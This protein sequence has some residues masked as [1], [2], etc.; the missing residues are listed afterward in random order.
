MQVNDFVIVKASEGE[1]WRSSAYPEQ[2]AAVRAAGKLAGAYHFAW[3]NQNPLTEAANFVGAADLRPGE[4]AALDMEREKAG[5]SWETRVAYALAWCDE[6]KRLTGA[7]PLVY[8]N[9]SWVKGLRSA[10]TAT[11]WARLTKYPCWLAEWSGTAGDFSTIDGQTGEGGWPVGMH[12]YAVIDDL[13]RD[14][15]PNIT[16]VRLLAKP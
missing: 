7:T 4:L 2:I 8:V 14:Y 6:V 13:D 16:S 15:I 1:G 11:Q 10:A 9:W 5:E 3:P 12:Q